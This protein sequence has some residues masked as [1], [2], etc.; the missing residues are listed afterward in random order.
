MDKRAIIFYCIDNFGKEYKYVVV[1]DKERVKENIEESR[2]HCTEILD[3]EIV[4]V[5]IR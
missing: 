5:D 4:S 2:R 1:C 3:Y